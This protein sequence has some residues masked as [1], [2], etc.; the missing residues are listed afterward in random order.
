MSGKEGERGSAE[1]GGEV[2]GLTCFSLP[3]FSMTEPVR[4]R[5]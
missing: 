5:P 4:P 3:E 1:A 2:W